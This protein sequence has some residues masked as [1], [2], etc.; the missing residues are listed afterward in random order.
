MFISEE[1]KTKPPSFESQNIGFH[2][3]VMNNKILYVT[4]VY[5]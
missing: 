4:E 2:G 5:F 3:N 1:Q